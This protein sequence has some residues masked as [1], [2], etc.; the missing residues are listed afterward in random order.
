MLSSMAFRTTKF[1]WLFGMLA[2]SLAFM[3]RDVQLV[4]DHLQQL[5][6]SFRP[7]HGPDYTATMPEPKLAGEVRR[8]WGA[9]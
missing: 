8:T 2:S 6:D 5:L 9:E 7:V 1:H 4:R 3:R